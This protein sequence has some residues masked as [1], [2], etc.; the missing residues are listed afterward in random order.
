MRQGVPEGLREKMGDVLQMKNH[1]LAMFVDDASTND[2]LAHRQG[3]LHTSVHPIL[4]RQ[5]RTMVYGL[6]RSVLAESGV[7]FAEG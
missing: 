2:P 6:A 7:C 4:L 3:T 1:I 5:S